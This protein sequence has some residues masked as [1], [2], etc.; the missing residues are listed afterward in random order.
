M[1]E[2]RVYVNPTGTFDLVQLSNCRIEDEFCSKGITSENG[3]LCFPINITRGLAH[4]LS[5]GLDIFYLPFQSG[6]DSDGHI[7]PNL[8][9]NHSL[10]AEIIVTDRKRMAKDNSW[11]T[12]RCI[13]FFVRWYV[14]YW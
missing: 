1:K 13:D 3:S 5:S 14:R 8:R 4:V 9:L 12:N 7:R 10:V 2:S 11:W 6:I